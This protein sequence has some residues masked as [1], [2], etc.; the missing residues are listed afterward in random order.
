MLRMHGAHYRQLTVFVNRHPL[1]RACNTK[2]QSRQLPSARSA[3][4]SSI[5]Q[6]AGNADRQPTLDEVFIALTNSPA[7]DEPVEASP[8][9]VRS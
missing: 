7:Y 9:G 2:R 5:K 6:P 1:L 3:L 4:Y 8:E